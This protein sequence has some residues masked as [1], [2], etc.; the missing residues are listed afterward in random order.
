MISEKIKLEQEMIIDATASF[1]SFASSVELDEHIVFKQT[2][3]TSY[4]EGLTDLS[5]LKHRMQSPVNQFWYLYKREF[6]ASFRNINSFAM[7]MMMLVV[8]TILY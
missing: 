2:R 5:T 3:A 7:K 6:I 8:T 4:A 1:A